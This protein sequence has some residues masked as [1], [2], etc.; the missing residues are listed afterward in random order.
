MT[1]RIVSLIVVLAACA[2][3]LAHAE[4]SSEP[5]TKF[6]IVLAGGSAENMMHIWLTPD[7]Y[8]YVI[9]SVVPLEVGGA[10]CQNASGNPNELVCDAPLVAGF[11]VNA[12]P[13]DDAVSVAAS[14]EV[15]TTLRGGPGDDVL[16][17]GD[18]ADKLVGGVGD[19]T[20][21]GRAGNDAIFGGPGKDVLNGGPGN[22]VL[23]GGPGKDVIHPGAG[24]DSV[25]DALPGRSK[26]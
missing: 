21:T 14:V 10:V 12:G 13:G 3:P 1:K 17:G 20:L 26:R 8:E 19:D 6:T 25:H 2:A 16:Q 5:P 11:E 15:P 18:A 9:D 4:T 7:G 22:D 23:W 24:R